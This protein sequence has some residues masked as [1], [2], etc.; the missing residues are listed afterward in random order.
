MLGKIDTFIFCLHLGGLSLAACILY[1]GK[2]LSQQTPKG[3]S[4]T[5][6]HIWK[7]WRGK[8]LWGL[9]RNI[10]FYRV[11]VNHT[12]F[13]INWKF[14]L[15]RISNTWDI[16][17]PP[18]LLRKDFLH[19][20][21]SVPSTSANETRVKRLTIVPGILQGGRHTVSFLC[22]AQYILGT[23]TFLKYMRY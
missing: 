6:S 10:W 9:Y 12:L 4:W 3:I 23:A 14:L 17:Y 15:V 13:H 5:S 1:L 22:C 16:I 2:S 18:L 21:G 19:T 7:V 8:W 20:E 11:L